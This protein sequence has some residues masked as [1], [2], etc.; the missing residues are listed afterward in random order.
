MEKVPNLLALVFIWGWKYD[1]E[2]NN[3]TLMACSSSG[4]ININNE[5]RWFY[6]IQE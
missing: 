1:K 2:V 6:H 4:V 5:A 3:D